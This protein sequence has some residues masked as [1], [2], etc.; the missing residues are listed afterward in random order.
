LGAKIKLKK[1]ALLKDLH[2]GNC[3]V[4]WFKW[5]VRYEKARLGQEASKGWVQQQ[6]QVEGP[7]V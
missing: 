6:D 3:I 4:N 2:L 1:R 5:I 7:R